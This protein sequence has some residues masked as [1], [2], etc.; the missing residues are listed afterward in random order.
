MG[1]SGVA[2][3]GQVAE[4]LA[5]RYGLVAG[6]VDGDGLPYATRAFGLTVLERRPARVRLVLPVEDTL[7]LRAGEEVGA[8]AVTASDPLTLRSVQLKGRAA[9]IEPATAEDRAVAAAY[10]DSFISAIV[11]IDRYDR[12]FL[13]RIVPE[14]YVVCTIVVDELYDQTPGPGA[15]GALPGAAR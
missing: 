13:Q 12:R 7:P 3:E 2:I 1:G 8:I 9:P 5:G 14:D 4:L 6:F 15:G 10:C 11:E